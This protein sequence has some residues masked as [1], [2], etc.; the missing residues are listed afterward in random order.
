MLQYYDEIDH[1]VA[2][3]FPSS[4]QAQ[5]I[6]RQDAAL[7]AGQASRA[8]VSPRQ[9]TGWRISAQQN[10]DSM[11]SSAARD[12]PTNGSSHP[13]AAGSAH[14]SEAGRKAVL[15]IMSFSAA[16]NRNINSRNIARSLS[17]NRHPQPRAQQPGRRRITASPPGFRDPAEARLKHQ[18][19]MKGKQ[20][21]DIEE[22]MRDRQVQLVHL[23][24]AKLQADSEKAELLN[25][26]QT[27]LQPQNMLH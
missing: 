12:A 21:F 10:P 5:R 18:M 2:A 19:G 8:A 25:T 4:E 14:S 13:R 9:P 3:K 1:R 27:T 22:F 24:K 16:Q 23:E 17:D 26:I 20:G 11:P 7:Q 15:G 6:R